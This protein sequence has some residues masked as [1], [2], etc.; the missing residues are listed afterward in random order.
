MKHI[1]IT[2]TILMAAS[3]VSCVGNI[4]PAEKSETLIE[5]DTGQFLE[6]KSSDPQENLVSDMNLF[7]FNDRG[8][9]ENRIY[10]TGAQMQNGQGSYSTRTCL[11]SG[12][13]YSVY[14]LA[15]A[16]YPLS[17]DKEDE[18]LNTRYYFTYPD[19]YR[20]GIPMAGKLLNHTVK[21]GEALNIRLERTMARISVS[22]DRSRLEKDVSFYVNSISI[23]GC[24]N[25]VYPFKKSQATSGFDT[26]L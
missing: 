21:E 18:V 10:L 7:I 4:L 17:M 23:G 24:P 2:L 15:N 14:A 9:L 22:I 3:A 26:F 13:T 11:L 19:E 5:F 25:S 6:T 20:T 1:G 8:M 16:G 12:G